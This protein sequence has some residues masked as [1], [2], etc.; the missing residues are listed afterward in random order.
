MYVISLSRIYNLAIVT[1]KDFVFC[2]VETQFLNNI[3][4]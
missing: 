1:E 4:R 3:C 2:E